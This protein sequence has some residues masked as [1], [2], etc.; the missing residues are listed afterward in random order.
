MKKLLFIFIS[1]FFLFGCE[2]KNEVEV[3]QGNLKSASF[4]VK[5]Q[6]N[7]IIKVNVAESTGFG[8]VNEQFLKTF[9]DNQ[10]IEVFEQ[11]INHATQVQGI[12]D[13][14]EPPY[15]FEIVYMD[16]TKKGYH[17]WLNDQFSTIMEV[18]ETHYIYRVPKQYSDAL[19]T[20]IP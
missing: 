18:E 10:S 7:N 8:V 9:E 3:Q 1:L 4:E 2:Q 5:E 16:G 15:D 11:A 20:I 14:M 13:M 17:L 19:Q 6:E 12:V